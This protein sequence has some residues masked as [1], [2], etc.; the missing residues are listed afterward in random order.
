MTR[1]PATAAMPSRPR[2]ATVSLPSDT[3]DVEPSPVAGA[4]PGTA[5][6]T[7]LTVCVTPLLQLMVGLKLPGPMLCGM[8]TVTTNW[9]G[10]LVGCMGIWSGRLM[11]VPTS[12]A[13]V[14]FPPAVSEVHETTNVVAVPGAVGF[15]LTVASG[16]LVIFGRL[17][18]GRA[19]LASAAGTWPAS[20]ATVRP[21]AAA[22]HLAR[23]TDH[24]PCHNAPASLRN[25]RRPGTQTQ[26]RFS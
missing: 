26:D 4:L 17:R 24:S 12:V 10:W 23:R 6:T 3:V 19:P 5:F 11:G 22:T 7:M 9:F 18:F 25:T 14:A 1:P 15:G 16:L 2:P 21:A 13:A 8:L 20:A